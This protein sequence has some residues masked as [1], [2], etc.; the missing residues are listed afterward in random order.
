MTHS[1]VATQ[2]SANPAHSSQRE[3]SPPRRCKTTG[4]D[5]ANRVPPLLLPPPRL[6]SCVLS[7]PGG[8]AESRLYSLTRGSFAYDSQFNRAPISWRQTRSGASGPVRILHPRAQHSQYACRGIDRFLYD[9]CQVDSECW[10]WGW[11]GPWAKAVPVRTRLLRPARRTAWRAGLDPPPGL[12]HPVAQLKRYIPFI[13]F[14]RART[15]NP[16]TTSQKA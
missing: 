14:P 6:W 10:D 15:T 13:R 2:D 9:A 16:A 7:H 12:V 5:F 11:T 3:R 4:I 8:S 1:R